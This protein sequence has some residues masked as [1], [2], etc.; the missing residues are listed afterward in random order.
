MSQAYRDAV[1]KAL[2]KGLNAYQQWVK[3]RLG[4]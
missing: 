1:T 4:E 3:G 2:V